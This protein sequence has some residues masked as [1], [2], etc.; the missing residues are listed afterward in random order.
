MHN[1][2]NLTQKMPESVSSFHDRPFKV[3]NGEAFA[4]ALCAQVT[5]PEVERIASRRLIGSID[6]FS[7]STDLRS[8]PSWRVTLKKLYE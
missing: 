3:I 8:Y 4:E 1:A 2:L 5:D 6:Q 7:D